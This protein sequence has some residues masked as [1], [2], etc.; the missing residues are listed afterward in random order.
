MLNALSATDALQNG[1][2]F[3]GVV[4]GDQHRD[5]LPDRLFRCVAKYS[6]RPHVP[7]SDA[8]IKAFADDGVIGGFDDRSKPGLR[9]LVLFACGDVDEDIDPAHYSSR[10]I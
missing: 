7:A 2:F 10:F 5:R 8:T 9:V 3:I 4:R 6:L 1:W